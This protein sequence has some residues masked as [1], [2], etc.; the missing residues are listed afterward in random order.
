MVRKH[1]DGHG[2][3]A[4]FKALQSDISALQAKIGD[5]AVEM[6]HSTHDGIARAMHSAGQT[7]EDVAR[8]AAGMGEDGAGFVRKTI[9]AKPLA[10][11]ALSISA[12]AVI[13][14]LLRG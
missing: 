12:G 7:A 2:V 8:Q 4:S 9:R 5:L 11:M 10:A 6:G 14:S 3:E 1:K 13:S